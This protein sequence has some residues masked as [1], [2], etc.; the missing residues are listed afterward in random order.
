[1]NL[2]LVDDE[3]AVRE[4]MA[5]KIEKK[6][7]IRVSAAADGKEAYNLF[8]TNH[9]EFIMTDIRMP[10]WD[11]LELI[12][13][14]REESSNVMIT[15]FT[16]YADFNYAQKAIKYHVNNCKTDFRK[17]IVKRNRQFDSKQ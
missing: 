15:V 5:R 1:M 3:R 2:L 6:F 16:A 14:V 9:Y 11:G 12:K 13:R 7:D 17:C 10:V 8:C 4:G